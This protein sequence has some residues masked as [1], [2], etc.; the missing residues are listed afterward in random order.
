[1]IAGPDGP[2]PRALT[3]WAGAV[4]VIALAT[5]N[6]ATRALLAVAALVM[7]GR[8]RR[9]AGAGRPPVALLGLA[10]ATSV[11]LNTLLSHTGNNTLVR[12]PLWL[13]GVGGRITLEAALFGLDIALGL[14]ACLVAAMTV[15]V[16]VEPERLAA[17]LPGPL[18][19]TGAALGAALALVPRLARSIG[20]IREAQQMRGWRA[21]GLRSWAAVVVPAVLTAVEGS[22]QLAEAMEARGFGTGPRTAYRVATRSRGDRAR[23]ACAA[24]A[25]GLFL[26]ASLT[27]GDPVWYPYPSPTGPVLAP[28]VLG[29]CAL[30]ILGAWL[31]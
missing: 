23:L 28:A 22:L 3:A 20:A 31:P 2:D 10:V 30:L 9:A 6:P 19:R 24:T 27:G 18:R 26:A 17:A 21:R 15:A 12:L 1:M 29:A 7:L 5:D 4:I 14:A 8:G 25:L 13:P 11:L 16:L